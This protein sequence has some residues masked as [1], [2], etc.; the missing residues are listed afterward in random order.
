MAMQM[1]LDLISSS[2][3]YAAVCTLT[4]CS[5]S[6]MCI[7][8]LHEVQAEPNQSR[9]YKMVWLFSQCFFYGGLL[10]LFTISLELKEE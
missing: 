1:L 9:N 10:I 6:V 5:Y 4:N 8:Q 3:S 7:L 2:A